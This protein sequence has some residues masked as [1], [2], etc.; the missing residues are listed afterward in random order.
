[1]AIDT[2]AQR[3]WQ[4]GLALFVFGLGFG[5]AIKALPNPR[6]ALSAHLNAVQSG[7][8]LI[9]LGLLWPQL[10]VWPKAA[11]ALASAIWISFWTL[12]AGMVLAALVP[13]DGARGAPL[14]VAAQLAT[15]VGA[16][17][18]MLAVGALILPFRRS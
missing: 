9:A 13:A 3:L 2:S 10:S 14:S 5:F 4:A 16:L 11:V 1:M 7:T 15:G 17:V 12:E 8:F 6:L 18:M